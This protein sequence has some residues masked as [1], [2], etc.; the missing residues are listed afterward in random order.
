MILHVLVLLSDKCPRWSSS[1]LF[2]WPSAMEFC[3]L[4]WR[5]C[6]LCPENCQDYWKHLPPTAALRGCLA[7][8]VSISW[9][10]SLAFWCVLGRFGA[11]KSCLFDHC[12][13]LQPWGHSYKTDMKSYD[14]DWLWL[15]HVHIL[16][17][18]QAMEACGVGEPWTPETMGADFVNRNVSSEKNEPRSL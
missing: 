15:M 14:Y 10:R 8:D 1:V 12:V 3:S 16:L 7:S 13:D 11:V 18:C 9:C 6:R 5:L 2:Q 17:S 4:V